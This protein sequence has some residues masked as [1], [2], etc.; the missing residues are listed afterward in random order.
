MKTYKNLKEWQKVG[1]LVVLSVSL[2]YSAIVALISTKIDT[3]ASITLCGLLVAFGAIGS[4]VVVAMKKDE[5]ASRVNYYAT[6]RANS[7]R[8]D[9]DN[10]D[11][12][13]A[14]LRDEL[15]DSTHREK[16]A[17]GDL[18]RMRE[19]NNGLQAEHRAGI[20]RIEVLLAKVREQEFTRL[21]LSEVNDKLTAQVDE[22]ETEIDN[23][24][25]SRNDWREAYD[26]LRNGD[27][28]NRY[29]HSAST[30]FA[31]GTLDKAYTVN[32]ETVY[33]LA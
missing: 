19:I 1:A 6:K 16:I 20:S 14:Y 32:G 22:Q 28:G 24:L 31:L 25:Q 21:R 23:L 8:E 33:P 13:I 2:G 15:A 10:R 30:A 17:S 29:T 11:E 27:N 9:I 12:E 5:H 3:M 18:A 4:G 26:K 7:L